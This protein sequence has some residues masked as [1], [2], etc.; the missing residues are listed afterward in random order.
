MNVGNVHFSKPRSCWI[1]LSIW[2]CFGW[3]SSVATNGKCP[4]GCGL[5]QTRPTARGFCITFADILS[6]CH[7]VGFQLIT[8]N[9]WGWIEAIEEWCWKK[10]TKKNKV[11]FLPSSSFVQRSWQNQQKLKV[12]CWSLMFVI[13][14]FQIVKRKVSLRVLMDTECCCY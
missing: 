7:W 5:E 10:K 9:C 14:D 13:L 12:Y 8:V 6:G 3:T 11:Y 4:E 2:S 1:F